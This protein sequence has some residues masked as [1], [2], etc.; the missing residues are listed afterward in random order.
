MLCVGAWPM[1]HSRPGLRCATGATT[2]YD[3]EYD[4]LLFFYSHMYQTIQNAY[5]VCALCHTVLRRVGEG[6]G[7]VGRLFRCE[8]P[9]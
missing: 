3:G 4:D 9:C 8:G 7:G 2:K 6:G 5:K 1:A